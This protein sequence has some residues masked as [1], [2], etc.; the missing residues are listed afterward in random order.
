MI[1][2]T[3]LGGSIAV[4][5]VSEVKVVSIDVINETVTL[6]AMGETATIPVGQALDLKVA[7]IF[8]LGE[9]V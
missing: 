6:E 8:N 5:I 1:K 9:S 7:G 2:E 4:T 3:T